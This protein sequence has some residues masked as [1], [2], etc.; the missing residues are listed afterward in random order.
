VAQTTSNPF[1]FQVVVPSARPTLGT[2]DTIYDGMS[3][4]SWRQWD[5]ATH[6]PW[7]N[8]GGDWLDRNR[9]PQGTTP[10]ATADVSF[11][12]FP[13]ASPIAFGGPGL[14]E[15][16]NRWRTRN[17][18]AVLN[19][20]RAIGAISFHHRES[21]TR[22]TLT[23]TAGGQSFS[24]RCI[25]F[26]NGNVSIAGPRDWRQAGGVETADAGARALIAFD[27]SVIPRGATVTNAAMTLS[28]RGTFDWPGSATL[29]VFEVD[30][31]YI[32]TT[33]SEAPA[34]NPRN[35][36]IAAN[37]LNDVGI[38]RH[39][40]VVMAHD[41]SPGW[42]GKYRKA[43]GGFYAPGE[44]N[45][46]GRRLPAGATPGTHTGW[47]ETP[48]LGAE[49]ELGGRT[50]LKFWYCTDENRRGT[51]DSD[52]DG[53][54]AAR[55]M[56]NWP[57]NNFDPDTE[58]LSIRHWLKLSGVHLANQAEKIGP[59][60]DGR[61]SWFTNTG[62][63]GPLAGNGG[64]PT[65]GVFVPNFA[66][67][68]Q[69]FGT[70][71]TQITLSE[72]PANMRYT[73]SGSSQE[74]VFV[75]HI[76]NVWTRYSFDAQALALETDGNGRITTGTLSPALQA[77]VMPGVR[78]RGFWTPDSFAT[79]EAQGWS[80]HYSGWSARVSTRG[81]G[82][83]S[84]GTP[85]EWIGDSNPRKGLMPLIVYFYNPL[86]VGF[87]GESLDIGS[88]AL[89]FALLKPDRGYS[90]ELLCRV[91]SL[92]GTPDKWGN[93]QAV[94]DGLIEVW[95]DG[96]LAYRNTAAVMRRHPFIKCLGP[97]IDYLQGGTE[98]P[99]TP[100]PLARTIGQVV[101]ARTYIGPSKS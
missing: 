4:L 2:L 20:I 16:V 49:P 57:V 34:S 54:S 17:T 1:R 83:Y 47:R 53:F 21:A 97:W 64:E 71:A 51:G 77:P 85:A 31:P 73:F 28:V 58:T 19:G 66:T 44:I 99:F 23:V 56:T 14:T 5:L 61:Y 60:I 3:G 96:V 74:A 6:I 35:A 78:I 68:S 95:I 38:D 40:D 89:G 10:F 70:G 75:E 30:A 24:C 48:A 65:R 69:P 41:F 90:I 52:R 33:S 22:P 46:S 26:N 81:G 79:L 39:P 37:Y 12:S 72:L 43:G 93:Q 62:Q 92:T 32:W 88:P 9:V 100:W 8:P 18:G 29:G 7:R 80:G 86:M 87:Y 101:A 59:S 36:G 42:E 55:K 82:W 63:W 91:N 84:G 25:A 15:L 67:V 13:G 11:T 98:V 76:P 50:T 94:P 45:Y 27:V